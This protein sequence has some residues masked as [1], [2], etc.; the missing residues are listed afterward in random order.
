MTARTLVLASLFAVV[1]PLCASAGEAAYKADDIVKYFTPEVTRGICVGTAEE[2]DAAQVKPKPFD[3]LVNFDKNSANLTASARD[4]LMEFSRA[5]KDP[6]LA[7]TQF[8]VEGYT[9]ASG[10]ETYNLS[11]SERRANA[12]VTFLGEQ[13]VDTSKLMAK[14]FGE[15]SPI[16]SDAY[17]PKNRRVQTRMA[18]Q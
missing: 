7:A 16:V 18:V 3:L 5:L 6:R 17:D 8:E 12:V 1:S 2:C 11:L 15:T 10:T 14:G 9:D 4:N 13:G